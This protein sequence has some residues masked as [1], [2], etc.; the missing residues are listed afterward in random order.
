MDGMG[1]IKVDPRKIGIKK[2]MVQKIQVFCLWNLQELYWNINPKAGVKKV[3]SN[4]PSLRIQVCPNKGISPMFPLWDW[5]WNP[6]NP[7]AAW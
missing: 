2:G 4:Y 3:L 6:Q 7:I 5:D 1:N